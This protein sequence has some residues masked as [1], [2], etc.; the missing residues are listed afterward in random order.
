MKDRSQAKMKSRFPA[1]SKLNFDAIFPK[2]KC[3][4]ISNLKTVSFFFSLR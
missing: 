1:K 4:V 3:I 2:K